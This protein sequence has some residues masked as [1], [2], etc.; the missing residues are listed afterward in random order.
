MHPIFN[1]FVL[2]FHYTGAHILSTFNP[3]LPSDAYGYL[4]SV[5]VIEMF[6]D[7]YLH[8][9]SSNH[10]ICTL[11]LCSRTPAALEELKVR[12]LPLSGLDL[13]FQTTKEVRMT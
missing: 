3:D 10:S 4:T 1:R 9:K 13:N 12:S 6:A 7:K 8:L 11:V 2:C 5:D